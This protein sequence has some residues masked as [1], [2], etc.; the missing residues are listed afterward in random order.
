MLPVSTSGGLP[1]AIAVSSFWLTLETVVRWTLKPLPFLFQASATWSS[2]LPPCPPQ[3]FHQSMTL[4]SLETGG[5]VPVGVGAP[6]AAAPPAAAAAVVAAAAGVPAAPASGGVVPA[7]PAAAVAPG[8]L[9]VGAAPQAASSAL[10]PPA[11]VSA[12]NF[13]RLICFPAMRGASLCYRPDGL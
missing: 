4:A 7:A 5:M 11:A 1:P 8:L 12:R 6:P 13:R 9:L 10:A 2:A 3:P